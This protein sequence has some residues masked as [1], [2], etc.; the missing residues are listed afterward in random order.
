MNRIADPEPAGAAD[1]G[2]RDLPRGLGT[3]GT[4]AAPLALAAG[5]FYY[6]QARFGRSLPSPA[7]YCCVPL[8]F[9]HA[10]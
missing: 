10:S 8:F 6:W 7:G 4:A 3:A 2:R 5:R 1:A 9:S